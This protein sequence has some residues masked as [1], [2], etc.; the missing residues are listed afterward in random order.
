M[1]QP[2]T[3]RFTSYAAS[4]NAGRPG[5]PPELVDKLLENL[6]DPQNLKVADLGAGTGLSSQLFAERGPTVYAIEP[7]AA[8]RAKGEAIRGIVWLDGTAEATGLPEHAIDVVAAFQAF[9]W[10]DAERA[11]AEIVR[12]LRPGGRAAVVFYERDE[13]DS[14]TRAYGELVRQFATDQTEARRAK[15]L[16]DFEDWAGW[17]STKRSVLEGEHILDRDGMAVRLASTSYLPQTGPQNDA[18]RAAMQA[19]FE[20][21][22]GDGRVRLALQTILVVA[23][24]KM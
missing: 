11:F 8:M 5:Y 13:R 23:E 20:Q 24:P 7:N 12:I 4:Y 6:G 1:T 9:H 2:E 3:E 16:K 14:F 19:L 15:A 10:F 22:A 18:M 21:H 17:R